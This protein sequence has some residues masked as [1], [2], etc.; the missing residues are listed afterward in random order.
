ML[1]TFKNGSL[2]VSTPQTVD[3]RELKAKLNPPL[4]LEQSLPILR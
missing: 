1:L 3:K 2:H 4:R